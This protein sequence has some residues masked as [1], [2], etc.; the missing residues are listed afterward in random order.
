[1]LARFTIHKLFTWLIALVWFANGL[2]CKVFNLVP[3]HQEIVASIMG[4]NNS[5]E[6]TI[7]IGLL[8][9]CMGVWIISGIYKRWN[10]L[11]QIVVV[12]VMNVIEYFMVPDLLL[13]GKWNALF[14]FIFV[15]VVFIN[16]FVVEAKRSNKSA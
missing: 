10:A 1:M 2:L 9:I 13:W 5:R 7:A 16:G 8:E 11:V 4:N 6:L 12:I 14:A 3:R 15:V